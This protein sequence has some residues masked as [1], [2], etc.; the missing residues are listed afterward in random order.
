MAKTAEVVKESAPADQ[1]NAVATSTPGAPPT[2]MEEYINEDAGQ[3]VST[4]AEDNIVPL[5][6]V[7]QAGSPQVNKRNEA[8]IEGAEPGFIWL[9]NAPRPIVD[10]E[11]GFLFQPCH[12]FRDVGEWIPRNPDGSGGGFVARWSEM[13][14]DATEIVPDP[15][16]PNLKKFM[17]PRDTE[18]VETR[19]HA[20]FVIMDDG[21]SVPYNIALSSTGHSVSKAWMGLQTSKY[22]AGKQA[23]AFAAIYRVKT[24]LRQRGSLSWFVM[25]MTDAGPDQ[26]IMWATKEQYLL[27]KKLAEAFRSGEK[28]AESLNQEKNETGEHPA[29][30]KDIPF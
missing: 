11:V 28:H 30:D 25:D 3:G 8:Y 26:T 17:S 24:K 13:P 19:N 21:R 29:G 18:Y 12:F 23:P 16:K 14:A 9:R 5:I 15:A 1:K 27:G 22:I 7:L 4:A 20:G 6:Y 2:F 10:G